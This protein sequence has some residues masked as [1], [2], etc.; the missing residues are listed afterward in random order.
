MQLI[1][2]G[3]FAPPLYPPWPVLQ[4]DLQRIHAGGV[5]TS[6]AAVT[7]LT[8]ARRR[9]PAAAGVRK[10]AKSKVGVAG[11]GGGKRSK[12]GRGDEGGTQGG[13]ELMIGGKGRRARG[14]VMQTLLHSSSSHLP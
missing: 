8:A 13:A 9:I 5:S 1:H 11:G 10:P 6:M 3:L 14:W 12:G 4:A 2:A 7:P